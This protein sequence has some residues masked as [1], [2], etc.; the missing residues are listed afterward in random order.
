MISAELSDQRNSKHA[1]HCGS[2]LSRALIGKFE[3]ACMLFTRKF[4]L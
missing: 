4:K 3:T 2:K 1:A